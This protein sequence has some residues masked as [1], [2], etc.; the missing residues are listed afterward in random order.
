MPRLPRPGEDEDVWGDILN[1][2][3]VV[4]HNDDGT[5]K[6]S[7]GASLGLTAPADLG[8]TAQAGVATTAA[9]SDHVHSMTGLTTSAQL[10][11]HVSAADPH[12]AASYGIMVGGGRRIY[13]QDT[14]PV[15]MQEGDV[16]IDTSGI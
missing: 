5:L 4:S 9:R 1:D 13:V 7:A 2:F 6:S 12:A 14:E 16:W 11:S 10:A 8:S 15:D 3:L